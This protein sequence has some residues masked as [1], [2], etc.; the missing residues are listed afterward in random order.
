MKY[1]VRFH[2]S[3]GKNYKHWQITT[4]GSKERSVTYLDPSLHN[5][6]MHDCHLHNV[7]RVA[8]K[9]FTTQTRDVCGWVECKKIEITQKAPA[10]GEMLIYDPKIKTNWFGEDGRN[11]DGTKWEVLFTHGKRVF[12][13]VFENST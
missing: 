10:T 3:R 1:K 13:P 4:L 9:V 12:S 8:Q 2:L 7:P 6:V 5:I 11:L